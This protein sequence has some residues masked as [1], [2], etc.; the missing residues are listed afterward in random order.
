MSMF[1]CTA[2]DVMEDSDFVGYR[3][4]EAG[5]EVCDEEDEPFSAQELALV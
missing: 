5:E 3:V 2:H 1:Y 4:T